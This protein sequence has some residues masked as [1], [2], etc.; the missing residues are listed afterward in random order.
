MINI[1]INKADGVILH[2]NKVYEILEDKVNVY[3]KIGNI[4][5]VFATLNSSIVE[6]VEISDIIS[7]FVG[8]KYMFVDGK[9]V[10]NPE[11]I[12]V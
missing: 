11:Y 7:N 10:L 3:D 6:V 8:N 4:L 12:E 9:I 1:L 2:Q 5:F